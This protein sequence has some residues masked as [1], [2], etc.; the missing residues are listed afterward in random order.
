MTRKDVKFYTATD[1]NWGRAVAHMGTMLG[2][3]S[4]IYV[5]KIMTENTRNK[6]RHEGADVIVVDGEY[7]LAVKE[8]ERI[9]I[10]DTGG[11]LIE[12]TAW[13]GYEKIPQ[14]SLSLHSKSHPLP[15][16]EKH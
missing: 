9:S 7:D 15:A 3:K 11:L 16:D 2:A 6:I 1:G 10:L 8:A 5:P 13:P 4:Q 14:V 12:D